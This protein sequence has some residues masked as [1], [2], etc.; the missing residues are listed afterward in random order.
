[1]KPTHFTPSPWPPSSPSAPSSLSG[2]LQ[3]S[4]HSSPCLHSY[5]PKLTLHPEA[6]GSCESINQAAPSPC[7]SP[8]VPFHC[9]G[10]SSLLLCTLPCIFHS[11]LCWRYLSSSNTSVFSLPQGLL[12]LLFPQPGIP[13]PKLERCCR[14]TCLR[15]ASHVIALK[16]TFPSRLFQQLR[17]FPSYCLPVP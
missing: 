3:R 10:L 15:L 5:L 11:E 12:R 13:F 7:C 8:S 1:M 2:L 4:P 14:C 6:M 9:L 16:K 17:P